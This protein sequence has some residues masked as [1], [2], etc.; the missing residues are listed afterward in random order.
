MNPRGLSVLGALLCIPLPGVAAAAAERLFSV[1][2][3][4]AVGI[5]EM[6]ASDADGGT[7]VR[8]RLHDIEA[9]F[10][11]VEFS[12]GELAV[13]VD[14]RYTRF[15]YEGIASRDRD[16]HTLAVP[17]VWRRESAESALSAV[18]LALVPTIATSSNVFQKFWDRGSREDVYLSGRLAVELPAGSWTWHLGA[19]ADRLWGDSRVYPIVGGERRFG[20]R[21]HARLVLPFP[22]L[23]FHLGSR[24]R[25]ALA[26]EPS[27][28]RWRVVSDD[29]SAHFDYRL[30]AFRTTA[31]WELEA[32]RQWTVALSAGF[33]TGRDHRFADDNLTAV[34]LDV[35]GGWVFGLK[36]RWAQ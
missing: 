24:Q 16:L 20:E 33:E 8:G 14:Y 36:L 15:E 32:H 23:R 35:D 2:R 25:L 27:G 4:L 9:G 28:Y 11:A 26:A 6:P 10:G 21:W 12:G 34:G 17:L 30:R 5:Q 3:F 7:T 31:S 19:A 22:E 1:D 13:G 18:E 29:F